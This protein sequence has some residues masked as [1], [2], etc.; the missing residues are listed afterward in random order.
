MN[1]ADMVLK[2]L[3]RVQKLADQKFKD[4][5]SLYRKEM[6]PHADDRPKEATEALQSLKKLQRT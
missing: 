5:V 3:D 6:G 4:T 1:A 2:E